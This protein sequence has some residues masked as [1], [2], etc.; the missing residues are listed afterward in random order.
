MPSSIA[1][2][3]S[4][5]SD[6]ESPSPTSSP[7]TS[8]AAH[9]SK[10]YFTA[11]TPILSG[12]M[13]WSHSGS[14][15]RPIIAGPTALRHHLSDRRR[16]GGGRSGL[17][18]DDKDVVAAVTIAELRVGALLATEDRRESRGSFLAGVLDVIR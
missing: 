13:T 12:P 4:P 3:I 5:S 1:A 10:R 11:K 7:C 18:I 8:G 17:L 16:P 15:W 2:S 14:W 9:R 6:E